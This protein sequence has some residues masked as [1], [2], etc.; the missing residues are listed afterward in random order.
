MAGYL[1]G[2]H[3]FAHKAKQMKKFVPVKTAADDKAFA[4]LDVSGSPEQIGL[5]IGEN[6]G[7]EIKLGLERRKNWFKKLKNYALGQGKT[8][9]EAMLKAASTY[10][11][12]AVEEVHGWAKG[13]GIPFEDLFIIN[14]KSEL[15]AFIEEKSEC[16]GCSTVVLKDRN[17]LIVAHNEDGHPAYDDL[18]FV[19]RVKPENGANFIAFTYPSVIEGN[20]PALNKH[21]LVYTTN[22]IGCR[23][24]KPRIPRYFLDRMVLEAKT[25]DEALKIT[26]HPERSYAY[27][28]IIA[29]LK[30]K[31][32]F[33][34]EATPSKYEV[35]EINGLFLHTNHLILETMK[36]SPQFD[37][38]I[39]LSSVP[40][41]ES[42]TKSLGSIKDIS[43]ITPETIIAAL[44]SH[45]NKPYSVCRHPE[46]DINGS[47]LG[48]ALF[49]ASDSKK[50]QKFTM[51]LYKNNPCKHKYEKYTL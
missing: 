35:K 31:K 9:F 36:N 16:A 6:F 3:L 37:K 41:L 10:T 29:S 32:A 23:E 21:G 40:R 5:A 47:T 33:S 51:R 11:P 12:K 48:T 14:C 46:G 49:T 20:A 26:Q 8:N 4:V 15:E 25:I 34:I 42:L 24:V 50:T 17:R 43:S 38:Y 27:H 45:E 39:K 19:I 30:E 22:Y 13:S 44:S 2:G 18:M 7:R 28:H 1:Y